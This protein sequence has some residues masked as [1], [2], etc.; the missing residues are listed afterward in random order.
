MRKSF[1]IPESEFHIKKPDAPTYVV[2]ATE[3]Q[4][5]TNAGTNVPTNSSGGTFAGSEPSAQSTNKEI[6]HETLSV[7]PIVNNGVCTA[8]TQTCQSSL[9]SSSSSTASRE[10]GSNGNLTVILTKDVVVRKEK[11]DSGAIIQ[12][13]QSSSTKSSPSAI[14]NRKDSDRAHGNNI[15]MNHH[16]N[17]VASNMEAVYTNTSSNYNSGSNSKSVSRNKSED[18]VKTDRS[19]QLSKSAKRAALDERFAL[20]TFERINNS[21]K[22]DGRNSSANS[23]KQQGRNNDDVDA[24]SDRDHRDRRRKDTRVGF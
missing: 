16:S 13:Q 21:N 8:V 2:S 6:V 4:I 11:V 3:P 5:G 24:R 19:D 17:P 15:S 10:L 12:Q 14:T 22:S 9:S 20:R 18:E 1:F 23:P 7:T